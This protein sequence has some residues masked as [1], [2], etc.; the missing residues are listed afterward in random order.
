MF[1]FK[2]IIDKIENWWPWKKDEKVVNPNLDPVLLIPGIGG[3]ILQA[4]TDKGKKERIWV[5]LFAADHEFKSKLWSFF[6]PETGLPRVLIPIELF[7]SPNNYIIL[8]PAAQFCRVF[9]V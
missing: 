6:N 4:V 8:H 1:D 5:R 9:V 3:S 2:D 7:P